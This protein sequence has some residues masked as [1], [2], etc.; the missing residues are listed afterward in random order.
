MGKNRLPDWLI[1]WI[2]RALLGEIYPEIR[3]ITVNF[4]N[5]KDLTIKFYLD[6]HPTE[7]DYE[8]IKCIVTNILSNTSSNSEISSVNDEAVFSQERIR[9][10]DILDILI[11]ARREY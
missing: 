2:W 5:N 3:A 4:T 11:Y 1:I 10:L 8:S 7:D 6:R 9:D